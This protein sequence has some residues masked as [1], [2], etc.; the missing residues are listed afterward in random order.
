MAT[1][2]KLSLKTRR[3]QLKQSRAGCFA[4][5]ISWHQRVDEDET[6]SKKSLPLDIHH[7]EFV[8]AGGDDSPENLVPICPLCH[9]EIHQKNALGRESATPQN[10]R[11]AWELWL[12]L[13]A[14]SLDCTLGL[15]P[16]FL[17]V[18]V[19]LPTYCLRPHFLVGADLRYQAARIALLDAV[20]TP[21]ANVDRH[22]PFPRPTGP[23]RVPSWLLSCDALAPSPAWDALEAHSVLARVRTPITLRSPL[24]ITLSRERRTLL[25]G[26]E[27]QRTL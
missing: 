24:V 22:F 7:V 10:I 19:D 21:L 1:R 15:E 18:S 2:R 23:I 14:L 4:H 9:R 8:S 11:A 16:P 6:A 27:E 5:R 26:N 17:S 3:I 12:A 25:E 20:L 13:G